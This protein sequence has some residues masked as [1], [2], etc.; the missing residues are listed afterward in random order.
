[1]KEARPALAA[2]EMCPI[3]PNWFGFHAL[4]RR[5]NATRMAG[6]GPQAACLCFVLFCFLGTKGTYPK[7]AANLK[8]NKQWNG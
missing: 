8:K 5:R 6:A 3:W 4:P 7:N 1:V 2:L